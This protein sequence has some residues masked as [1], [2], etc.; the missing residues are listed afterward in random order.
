MTETITIA[1]WTVLC[2]NMMLMLGQAAVS[3][4]NAE[5]T[6]FI[7]CQGNIIGTFESNNCTGVYGY[8]LA[9]S[10]PASRLPTAGGG[11]NADGNIYTDSPTGLRSWFAKIDAGVNYMGMMLSAPYHFLAA[12]HAPAFFVFIVGS[13]WYLFSLLLLIAFIFGRGM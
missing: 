5:A 6:Q 10:D 7:N 11:I 2:I 8:S 13:T 12:L 1:F 4:V 3:D 9:D